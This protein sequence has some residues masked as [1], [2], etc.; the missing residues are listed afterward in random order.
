MVLM[1]THVPLRT[2]SLHHWEALS[3]AHLSDGSRK[4]VDDADVE[5]WQREGGDG[6]LAPEHL[7]GPV[8]PAK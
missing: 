8:A 5:P 3:A 7:D 2:V 6:G 4:E 1:T